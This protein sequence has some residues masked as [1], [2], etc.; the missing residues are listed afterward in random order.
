MNMFTR[1]ASIVVMAVM[2]LQIAVFAAAGAKIHRRRN[3]AGRIR[4]LLDPSRTLVYL[5][6]RHF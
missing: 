5:G 3:A 2:M 1:M 4:T 6:Q